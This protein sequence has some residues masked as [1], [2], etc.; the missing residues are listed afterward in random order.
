MN[1]VKNKVQIVGNVGST[2]ELKIVNNKKL[3]KLSVAVNEY[4]RYTNGET[5]TKTNWHTITV[6]G[7]LAEQVCKH[8]KKGTKILVAGKL[9]NRVYTNKLGKKLALTEIVANEVVINYTKQAA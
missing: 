5:R 6:W 7:K 3:T 1:T 2:P 8:T 9:K 4:K